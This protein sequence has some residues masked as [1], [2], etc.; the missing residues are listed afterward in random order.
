[1]IGEQRKLCGNCADSHLHYTKRS[2]N[3]YIGFYNMVIAESEASNTFWFR[4]KHALID[5]GRMWTSFCESF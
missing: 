1:M 3:E 5:K 2:K 4:M